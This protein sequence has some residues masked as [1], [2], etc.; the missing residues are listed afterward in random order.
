MTN[1]TIQLTSSVFEEGTIKQDVYAAMEGHIIE[2]A[3]LIGRYD[4]VE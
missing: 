1:T 3:I 4:R 2:E